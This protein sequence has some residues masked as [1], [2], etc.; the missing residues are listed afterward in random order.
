MTDKADMHKYKKTNRRNVMLIKCKNGLL[1]FTERRNNS[2][3]ERIYCR[4]KEDN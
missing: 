3:M 4:M 1:I 2:K